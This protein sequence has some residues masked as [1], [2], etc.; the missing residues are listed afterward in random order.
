MKI[1]FFSAGLLFLSLLS[2]END[3]L[4]DDEFNLIPGEIIIGLD[5]AFTSPQLFEFL[6]NNNLKL[7]GSNGLS[8]YSELHTD[9]LEFVKQKIQNLIFINTYQAS[10][11]QQF[12]QIIIKPDFF[13]LHLLSHQ[14][15]W[16]QNISMLE[17]SQMDHPYTILVEVEIGSEVEFISKNSHHSFVR[18]IEQNTLIRSARQLP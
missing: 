17:L 4:N 8:Y 18:F 1:S 15:Q 16:L 7:Q 10:E 3:K 9:S 12:Q 13:D 2:C 6:N 5:G 11:D 14:K